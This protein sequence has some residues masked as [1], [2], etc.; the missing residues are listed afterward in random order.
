MEEIIYDF[1]DFANKFD[2]KKL[3]Y[4][5]LYDSNTLTVKGVYPSHALED[6]AE[7]ILIDHELAEK[8]NSGFLN[9][10][11][12]KVNLYNRTVEIIEDVS[13]ISIDTVLHRVI[14][15]KWNVKKTRNNDISIVYDTKSKLLKFKIHKKYRKDVVWPRNLELKFIITGYNDPHILYDTVTFTLGNII[16]QD[17]I[18]KE[19]NID[20]EFSIFSKRVFPHYQLEIL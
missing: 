10:S 7:A 17:I 12:C 15:K 6:T 16:E 19:I 18:E 14:E 20:G 13:D 2:L 5:A 9:M 3:E 1:S 4:Y 11:K 8:I